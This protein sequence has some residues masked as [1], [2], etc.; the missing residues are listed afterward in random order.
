MYFIAYFGVALLLSENKSL[1]RDRDRQRDR[2]RERT[3]CGVKVVRN[4]RMIALSVDNCV[5]AQVMLRCNINISNGLFNSAF[6][7]IVRIN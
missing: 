3:Y 2:D 1:E 5:G 7:L 4:Y 6:G